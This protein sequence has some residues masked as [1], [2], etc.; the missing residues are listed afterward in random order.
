M[1]SAGL[2]GPPRRGDARLCERNFVGP[3][4]RRRAQGGGV[5]F[6]VK[7]TVGAI[8]VV[9][10]QKH[11]AELAQDRALRPAVETAVA[12]Q[13]ANAPDCLVRAP[14][15][16]LR[17]RDG[18]LSGAR[19]RRLGGEKFRHCRRGRGM[20]EEVG[21]LPE[22]HVAQPRPSGVGLGE[23]LERGESRVR[24]GAQGRPLQRKALV[25]IARRGRERSERRDV[26]FSVGLRCR[27]ERRRLRRASRGGILLLRWRRG[28]FGGN[29]RRQRK[30][31]DS[32]APRLRGPGASHRGG[33]VP[34]ANK[35]RH[36]LRE[37]FDH[38]V[39]GRRQHGPGDGGW[40]AGDP[41]KNFALGDPMARERRQ[42][43]Q[44]GGR[45][46]PEQRAGAPIVHGCTPCT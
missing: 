32:R 4:K 13:L 24:I 19:L 21:L 22:A 31:L 37:R 41:R 11:D 9:G 29:L 23:S 36:V 6:G 39:R 42:G 8:L 7:Q 33:I 35:L 2:S 46:G 12:P 26:A 34:P 1:S 18:E 27:R 38:L 43:D 14:L 3:C 30:R 17:A 20:N 28:G 10:L 16:R 45:R 40:R 25:R 15:H 5:A 44:D